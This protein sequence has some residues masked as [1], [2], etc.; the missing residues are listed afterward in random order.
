MGS[1]RLLIR[2]VGLFVVGGSLIALLAYGFTREPREIPTPL[3]GKPATPFT[4]TLFD[5]RQL[6]LEELR[7]KVV[8]LNFWA[9][10]CPPCRAE[11]RT[12]EA[13]WQKYKERDVVFLGIDIQDTEED[14]KAFLREFGITYPNGR[15]ASGKLAIDYGVWGIPETFIINREGRI[16]YKHVGALGWQTITAK[17]DEGLQGIVSARE[18]K[19]DYRQIR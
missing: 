3:L 8:F 7:G 14:A 13:A 19:G 18:G 5:G 17:L 4:L 9:S 11:A 16:T 10:W 2:L 12:L 1:R 6:S 15:D